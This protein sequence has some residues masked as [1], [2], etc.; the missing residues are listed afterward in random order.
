MQRR[1]QPDRGQPCCQMPDARGEPLRRR[2]GCVRGITEERP[3]RES[4]KSDRAAN[5][6]EPKE[7]QGK[8][9]VRAEPAR[10]PDVGGPRARHDDR[11]AREEHHL[12]DQHDTGDEHRQRHQPLRAGIAFEAMRH[13]E[14]DAAA[15][16]LRN[17]GQ[18]HYN[19]PDGP[20]QATAGRSEWL[21]RPGLGPVVSVHYC[22]HW[23]SAVYRDSR[24]PETCPCAPCSRTARRCPL[25]AGI[26]C[27][28][29]F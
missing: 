27:S 10:E 18:R 7:G 29:P 2:A 6:H 15:I 9:G 20:N 1:E 23:Q 22:R 5:A 24:V 11:V 16:L 19:D 14:V 28:R 25:C 13:H 12:R 4:Q 3:G 21:R 26:G 8:S 17:G